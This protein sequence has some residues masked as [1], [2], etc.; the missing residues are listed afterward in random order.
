[1][2]ILLGFA[3]DWDFAVQKF[4]SGNGREPYCHIRYRGL[5][6]LFCSMVSGDSRQG[7]CCP[8]T[9]Q[10]LHAHPRPLCDYL[11]CQVLCPSVEA[12]ADHVPAPCWLQLLVWCPE[13]HVVD[14]VYH[15]NTALKSAC[16]TSPNMRHMPEML[17]WRKAF[18]WRPIWG[19]NTVRALLAAVASIKLPN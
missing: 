3:L 14:S 10:L 4:L 11:S 7:N 2:N 6:M 15:F 13:S 8:P 1:M 5:R 16:W 17:V 18:C 19:Q 9:Q 12:L